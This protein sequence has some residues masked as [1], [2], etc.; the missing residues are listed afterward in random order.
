L[1]EDAYLRAIQEPLGHERLSTAQRN[2]QLTQNK[3]WKF[4]IRPIHGVLSVFY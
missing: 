2:T 3:Y 4:T 1:E